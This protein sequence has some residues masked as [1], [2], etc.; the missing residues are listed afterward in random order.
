MNER[1]LSA[2]RKLIDP[3]LAI[4]RGGEASRES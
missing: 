3:K 2:Y 4:M 1:F